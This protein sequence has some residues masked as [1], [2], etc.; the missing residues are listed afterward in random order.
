MIVNE[1]QQITIETDGRINLSTRVLDLAG[2][3]AGDKL[4][5]FTI[6]PGIIQLRKIEPL[7]EQD[8]TE[9]RERLRR[10]L[11]EAGYTQPEQVVKMLRE[12][13]QEMA[14]E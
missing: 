14:K 6:A 5:V 7:P 8:V 3:H 9:I 4:A 1:Q 10:V 13:R 2:I 11:I 12:I